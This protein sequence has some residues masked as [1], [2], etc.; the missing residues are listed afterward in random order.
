MTM[1]SALA[2]ESGIIPSAD[3]VIRVDHVY[4]EYRQHMRQLSLRHETGAALQRI[5]RRYVTKATKEP[6]YA[7][8]DVSFTV[9][10]GESLGVVGRN[11]AGKTTLLRL[12]SNITRPTGGSIEVKGR[13]ATLIGVSAGFNFD[14]PGRKN[15]YLNAAF[16]GWDP[17]QVREIEPQIVEFADIGTFMDA[18]V[19][20]Y[21][22]GMIARLGFSIA[23]HLLPDI[24][25]L[26]EVLSVGDAQFAAK[27]QERIRG[28]RDE[29][30]TIVLVSHSSTSVQEMCTRAI[31]LDRGELKR[32]G[33]TEEV[34]AAYAA[35]Q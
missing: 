6:F 4:K 27:C 11:G 22:S 2:V 1:P 28:F 10:K 16:F 14:M 34:L 29:Q 15:I 25:F 8:R 3:D 19:K 35:S 23:I 13:F 30:R 20:V 12:L 26:D 17:E 24:I 32:D 9:Q 5:L 33:S 7:L 31:W 21:S 18:P